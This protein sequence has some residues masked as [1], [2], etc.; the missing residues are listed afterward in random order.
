MLSKGS[1]HFGGDRGLWPHY[2]YTIAALVLSAV[3]M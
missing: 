1:L 2:C 3:S